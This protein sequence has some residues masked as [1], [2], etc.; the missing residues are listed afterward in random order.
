MSRMSFDTEQELRLEISVE[1][2][3]N[4]RGE[5]YLH[6]HKKIQEVKCSGQK[7]LSPDNTIVSWIRAL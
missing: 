3:K 5:P 7:N 2:R 6:E 4:V 1:P